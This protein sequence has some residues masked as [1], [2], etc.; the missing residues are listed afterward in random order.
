MIILEA[1]TFKQAFISESVEK[2]IFAAMFKLAL[3]VPQVVEVASAV[4]PMVA[5]AREPDDDFGCSS[6]TAVVLP[7]WAAAGLAVFSSEIFE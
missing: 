4:M 3:T 7:T 2:V 6:E 1:V 5:G